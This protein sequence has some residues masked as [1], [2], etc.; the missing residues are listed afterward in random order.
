VAANQSGFLARAIRGLEW[1]VGAELEARAHAAILAIDHREIRFVAPVTEALFLVGS[2]D[3]IFFECGFVADVPHTRDALRLLASAVSSLPLQETAENARALNRMRAPSTM[4]VVASF[5]GRRNYNRYEIEDA[6]GESIARKLSLQYVRHHA[7]PS[8]SADLSWRVHIRDR[9]AFVGLRL[10][11][12]PLHRRS[13]KV[14]SQPGSLH[15]PVAYAMGALAC[16]GEGLVCLD[17][18]CGGATT[19]IEA[20]RLEPRAVLVGSD[21]DMGALAGAR[22]NADRAHC[23]LALAVAD[24]GRLPYPDESIDR[25]VA[26]LP[27]GVQVAHAGRMAENESVLLQ[28]LDRVLAAD[29]VAVLLSR[30]EDWPAEASLEPIWEDRIHLFGQWAS[31]RIIAKEASRFAGAAFGKRFW[32]RTAATNVISPDSG[33]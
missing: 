16:L 28:E 26:N 14:A 20:H 7:A 9:Q 13:Y 24:A 2:A 25:I 30:R 8:E 32:P 4:E 11:S 18:C 10:G 22:R 19:L 33:G 5:L 29:G 3:D 1:L 15:P 17:P 6:A 23:P 21:I 31:V 27:W 12:H